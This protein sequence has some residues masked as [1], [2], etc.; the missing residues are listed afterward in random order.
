MSFTNF[1]QQLY[2]HLTQM[3]IKS[4]MGEFFSESIYSICEMVAYC[5][6]FLLTAYLKEVSQLVV[7]RKQ[8]RYHLPKVQALVKIKNSTIFV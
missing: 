3:Y 6:N 4:E 5:L 7:K 8:Y 2:L 1:K